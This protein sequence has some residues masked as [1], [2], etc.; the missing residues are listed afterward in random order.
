MQE[1]VILVDAQDREIGAGEKLAVHQSGVLHRAFSI[2]I[3]NKK[4]EML[5][6]KRAR[7]KYHSG[8]LWSNACC[9]HPRPGEE[10]FAAAH[11]RLK[12]E[13]GLACDLKELYSFVY[14]AGLDQG[15][16]EHEYD[17]VFVGTCDDAPTLNPAEAEDW[18]WTDIETLKI[19]TAQH[20]ESYTVWFRI[21]MNDILL[22]RYQNTTD[23]RP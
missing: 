13:M 12:E 11:R 2:F 18:R 6:Q 15:L 1:D 10:I 23:A 22:P 8:G 14:Q 20:P 5:L 4:G 19:D 9:G 7:S 17:H 16:Q 3:F 21:A